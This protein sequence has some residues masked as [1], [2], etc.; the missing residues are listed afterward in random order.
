LNAAM[1]AGLRVEGTS[2]RLGGVEVLRGVDL[3]VQPGE[4]VGLIGPNGVG[5][6]TLLRIVAG[7]L[8]P[9]AG[10][11]YFEGADV[12]GLT[13]AERARSVALVPQLAPVTFGFTAL[14][15]V[16]MGQYP[17]LGRFQAEGVSERARTVEA[18]RATET[19]AFRDRPVVTLS[20]GERQRVF[21]ARALAQRPRLL[22]LD[23]PTSNLDVQYQLKVLGLVRP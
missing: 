12:A 4:F 22:L 7:L 17:H 13:A 16:T 5:K 10:R 21:L 8:R 15:V 14:E 9:H 1:K 2:C 6:S 3:K 23:E 20:G 19:E 11:V 18:L